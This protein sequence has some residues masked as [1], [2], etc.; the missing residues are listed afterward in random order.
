MGC[1]RKS[2]NSF[3]NAQLRHEGKWKMNANKYNQFWEKIYPALLSKMTQIRLLMKNGVLDSGFKFGNV[4]VSGD[5]EYRLNWVIKD[6]SGNVKAILYAE[7][8]D[9]D[10]NGVFPK[11]A[12]SIN[13][14]LEGFNAT[15]LVRYCPYNYSENAFSKDAAEIIRRIEELD[16]SEFAKAAL[17]QFNNDEL[18]N[19]EYEEHLA[20]CL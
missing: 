11:N 18:L 15:S 14:E 20:E 8:Y 19:K 13:I 9:S 6:Y 4:F 3:I 12:V 2:Q 17:D 1:I 5:A 10:E 7:L 16:A